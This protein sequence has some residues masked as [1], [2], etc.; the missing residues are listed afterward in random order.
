MPSRIQRHR[1]QETSRRR[2]DRIVTQVYPLQY[3]SAAQ[4]VPV[5][6]PLITPNNT[7]LRL[8][9]HQYA[10]DHRLC[11]Q[12][13]AHRQ[14][15]RVDRPAEQRRGHRHPAAIR[16][17]AGH[18][19]DAQPPAGEASGWRARS[20]GCCSGRT[21]QRFMVCPDIRTNSLLIRSDNPARIT[22]CAQPGRAT[23]YAAS[24]RGQYPRGLSAQCRSEQTGGNP[25]RDPFRRGQIGQP[26]RR[27]PAV[28]GQPPATPRAQLRQRQHAAANRIQADPATNSLIITA[29]DNVYNTLRAVIDKLDARRAQVYVEALIV[30]VTTDKAAEFGIQW[31]AP[32]GSS[33]NNRAVV[34][35]T[36]FGAR[37]Q[38]YHQPGNTATQ[39]LP[40]TA[41]TSAL[42]NGITIGGTGS[43]GLTALARA[44][45]SDANANILSTPN[46]LTLDNE[47]AKIVVGQNVPFIT[48]SYAQTGSATGSD[49]QPVPDH[50]AQGRRPDAEGQ[51]AGRRRRHGQAADLPGGLQHS[52]H[53]Q[54][55]R[56]HH[57]Q[58]LHRIHG[59]G[60]RRPDHRAGR[61][62]PGRRAATAW[63][64]SRCWAISRCSAAC[65]STR[66]ASTS[67]PT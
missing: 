21:G 64:R 61:P 11:R 16:V 55:R 1:R 63:T 60:G 8:R 3:E 56:R 30:E 32:L 49:G 53:H 67:R 18:G 40:N 38:Q 31:Q 4:L 37:R 51:A 34:G 47:E 25:A 22:P 42:L 24:A 5:L 26:Q 28:P 45:E 41:S 19:A 59:A 36:N 52:G 27:L 9:Q 46:L 50:R 15:H 39:C 2:G 48:G 62:D 14:D 17:R 10:G 58:A 33:G 54:R 44:L 29:P 23:G 43:A 35:G 66:R 6:R 7:H 12:P 57:Q 13:E 65:S 20:A